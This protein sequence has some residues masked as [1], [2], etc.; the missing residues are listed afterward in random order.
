MPESDGVH[1]RLR[2]IHA[3]DTSTRQPVDLGD[4]PGVSILVL[5]RHRH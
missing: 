1:I 2:G 3:V 4:L 5:M